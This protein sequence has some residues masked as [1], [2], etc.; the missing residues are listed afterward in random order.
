MKKLR[1]VSLIGMVGLIGILCTGCGVYG[2]ANYADESA[3][4]ESSEE[5]EEYPDESTD[6]SEEVTDEESESTEA[7]EDESETLS[8]ECLKEKYADHKQAYKT[9]AKYYAKQ[10]GGD[11]SKV[12]FRLAYFND[13]DIPE[14]IAGV[15]GYYVSVYQFVDGNVYTIMENWAYGAGGNAGYRFIEKTGVVE[16]FDQDGAGASYYCTYYKLNEEKH[17]M[18]E[19]CYYHGINE[20][21]EGDWGEPGYFKI[22]NEKESEITKAD[23]DELI[24]S[25]GVDSNDD[26]MDEIYGTLN[27]D[28]LLAA[29]D[30]DNYGYKNYQ[31]A[32]EAEKNRYA[33]DNGEEAKFALINVTDKDEPNL[34]AEIPGKKFSLY[35]LIGGSSVCILQDQD[36]D[37]YGNDGFEYVPGENLLKYTIEDR[38]TGEVEECWLVIDY[39]TNSLKPRIWRYSKKGEK[40]YKYKKDDNFSWSDKPEIK[41]CTEEEF[42][43]KYSIY[44][45]EKMETKPLKA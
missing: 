9:I 43:N 31:D 8:E 32:F 28:E 45:G 6:I 20:N 34:L 23:Y 2:P 27:L 11:D 22:V 40:N 4:Y 29:L 12:K 3:V 21:A 37:T 42:K 33:E 39:D 41:E 36:F 25:F 15:N 14:L 35:S 44:A 26:E 13:D 18:E 16:N 17:E 19:V 1:F 10:Y 30:N 5:T 38:D 24:K 7:A